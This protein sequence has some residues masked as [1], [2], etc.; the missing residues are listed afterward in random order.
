[1]SSCRVPKGQIGSDDIGLIGMGHINGLR[2]SG[3]RRPKGREDVPP[4]VVGA[5]LVSGLMFS[6][7]GLL[8]GLLANSSQRLTLFSSIII[9]PMTFLCGTLFDLSALPDVV[10]AVVYVLPLTHVSEIMRGVMLDTGVPL[11]SV[12]IVAF[13]TLLF[14]LLSWWMIKTRRC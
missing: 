12:V 8:A 14:F 4:A 11:D 3:F 10:A 2:P 13:F 5:V 6:L 7:F 9:V 1:M